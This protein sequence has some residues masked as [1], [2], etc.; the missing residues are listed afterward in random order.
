MQPTVGLILFAEFV[1]TWHP[2]KWVGTNLPPVGPDFVNVFCRGHYPY[3]GSH[4]TTG[5]VPQ[6]VI[7]FKFVR[8]KLSS[9]EMVGTLL[10]PVRSFFNTNLQVGISLNMV[11]IRRLPGCFWI[12]RV[13]LPEYGSHATFLRA[14]FDFQKYP[15]EII[16][17][18]PVGIYPVTPWHFF[19][20]WSQWGYLLNLVADIRESRF[21]WI[22]LPSEG[23]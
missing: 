8:C 2:L 7:F 16:T 10:A 5:E 20:H 19:C 22:Y 21:N 1:T 12:S 13:C 23:C 4:V 17:P 15:L 11:A 3:L 6:N 14:G 18:L 9:A